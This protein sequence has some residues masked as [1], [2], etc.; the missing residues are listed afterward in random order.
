MPMTYSDLIA[1]KTN[2]QSIQAWVNNTTVPSAVILEDAQA[3]I[4]RTLR[5]VEMRRPGAVAIASAAET[6]NLPERTIMIEPPIIVYGTGNDPSQ[7]GVIVQVDPAELQ[8]RSHFL[9]TV[10]TTVVGTTTSTGTAS[11]LQRGIPLRYALAGTAS[12]V[13]DRS[14]DDGYALRFW[15]WE[16]PAALGTATETNFVTSRFPRMLRSACLAFANEW[17][18]DDSEKDRW[19]GVCQAEIEMANREAETILR[20][21]LRAEVTTR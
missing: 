12:G 16:R 10:T 13:F 3:Y 7:K 17:M 19:L 4:Y 20:R 21:D 5:A 14:A 9:G 6:F 15:Y 11:W 8:S 1:G 2:S 18:K